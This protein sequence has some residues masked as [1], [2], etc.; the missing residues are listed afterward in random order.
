MN[1]LDLEFI[2]EIILKIRNWN[3]Y[4]PMLNYDLIDEN[5]SI[6]KV[7]FYLDLLT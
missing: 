1:S 7:N 5:T 6:S 2:R 3:S 4:E